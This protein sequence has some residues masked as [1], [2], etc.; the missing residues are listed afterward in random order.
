MIK[1]YTKTFR[2][3]NSEPAVRYIVSTEELLILNMTDHSAWRIS[4]AHKIA[5]AFTANPKVE[6]C[7]VFGSAALGISDQYS[8]LELAFIWSQLPSAEELQATAQSVGVRSWEIEPYGEAKQ[9]WL[10]QFYTYGMKV[11]AGHWER[12]T[13]DN[14]VIDVVERYDVSQSGLLFEKQSIASHLQRA[15]I[16]HGEDIIKQWQTQIF[17]YPEELAVAMVQKHLKFR[18]FDGQQILTERL[19]IPMLYENNCA[20]VRWLLNLLF[21]V[22]RIYHPGFKWTRYFIEEMNIK[23]P[24]FFA[25]LEHVFQSEAASGTHELQRLVEETFDLVEQCLPQ[26]DL[27]QQ[28]ETFNRLYPRWEVPVDR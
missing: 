3:I 8:D 11:E 7:F 5:P 16:L 23:P 22:N 27:K 20:I 9:A 17:P 19:E 18:P 21:G 12:N 6:A 10:E 4:L 1:D 25:R 28:R 24:E 13:I 14:I 2:I 26:V 15:V